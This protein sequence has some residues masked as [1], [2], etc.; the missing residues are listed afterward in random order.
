MGANQTKPAAMADSAL[1]GFPENSR[2]RKRPLNAPAIKGVQPENG[3]PSDDAVSAF[4]LRV[5]SCAAGLDG[6]ALLSEVM[7][8]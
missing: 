5:L 6:A 3:M 7:M 2:R 4:A 8:V 1:P